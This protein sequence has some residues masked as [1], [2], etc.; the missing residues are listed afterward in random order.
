MGEVTADNIIKYRQKHGNKTPDK[1]AMIQ[2][3][4]VSTELLALLVDFEPNEELEPRTP[5]SGGQRSHRWSPQKSEDEQNPTGSDETKQL[6][7]RVD[8][9]VKEKANARFLTKQTPDSMTCATYESLLAS[10][11]EDSRVK[12]EQTGEKDLSMASQSV[13]LEG[14]SVVNQQPQHVHSTNSQPMWG[15]MSGPMGMQPPGMPMS[16]IPPTTIHALLPRHAN[17]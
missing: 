6:I 12:R 16:G 1:L 2:F 5:E 13:G 15:Q 14:R 11:L 17:R 4:R 8:E 9:L 7:E 3:I 10:Q